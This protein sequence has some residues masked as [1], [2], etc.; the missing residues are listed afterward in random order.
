MSTTARNIPARE[1]FSSMSGG[2]AEPISRAQP[3]SAGGP[4]TSG[5][6]I[7]VRNFESP[8]TAT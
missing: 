2:D 8:T 4:L 5:A 3:R 1:T 6:A 7:G